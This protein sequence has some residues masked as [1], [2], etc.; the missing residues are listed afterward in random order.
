MVF[1]VDTERIEQL[2][3]VDRQR[4]LVVLLLDGVHQ[5]LALLATAGVEFQQTVAA[6]M[7]LGFQALTL[8]AG[9]VDQALEGVV[10]AIFQQRQQARAEL[11][12]QGIAGRAG[13]QEGVQRFVVP[14]EQALL[15]AGFQIGHVQLNSV[16]LADTVE[17]ADAL[18]EQVRMSRQIEQ[19]QMVAEL[20]VAA[21]AADFRADQHLRAELL[22]GEVGRGAVAFED[23]HAF[24]EYRGR[25]AG[26]HAQ[27]VLQIQRGL[28]VGADDQHLV[29]LQHL[30]G[31]DQPLDAWFDAPPALLVVDFV[32][33]LIA[34]F[35]V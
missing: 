13:G 17:A 20:E 29:L 33:C 19:H 35:R 12:L 26:A 30:Q 1:T 15:R 14:L 22:V 7:Q 18:L 31:V 11:M 32:L 24:V 10:I 3:H 6:G 5:R 4:E 9:F 8:G 16:L 27:R 25:D 34:D 21:F 28:G 2:L 23:A